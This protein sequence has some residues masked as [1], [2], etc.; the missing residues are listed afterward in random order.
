M[1]K[2]PPRLAGLII[3]I[4]MGSLLVGAAGQAWRNYWLLTDG[5]QGMATVIEKHWGGHGR[6]VYRYSVDGTVYTGVGNR[7]WEDPRYSKVQPGDES[8]V[9]YS[10]SRPW[11][12]QLHKPRTVIDDL[13]LPMMI[14]VAI[15]EF[16]AVMTVVNPKGKWALRVNPGD[17]KEGEAA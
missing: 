6:V 17:R 10:A 5:Q 14:L 7:N 2:F 12:S 3:A 13:A 15:I 9:Y 8:V 4:L 16:F 11:I 1:R